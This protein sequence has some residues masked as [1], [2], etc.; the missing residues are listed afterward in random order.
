MQK[1][2]Q[3]EIYDK[4]KVVFNFAIKDIEGYNNFSNKEIKE[5]IYVLYSR[6]RTTC[7]TD[8]RTK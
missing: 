4:E 1:K 6:H 2:L 7:N 8:D 3:R 5:S